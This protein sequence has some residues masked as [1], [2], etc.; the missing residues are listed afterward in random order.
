MAFRKSAEAR[1]QI[2]QVTPQAAIPGGEFQIRGKGLLNGERP[3]VNLG[4]IPAHVVIGSESFG[5]VRGPDG[6]SG[7]GELIGVEPGPAPWTCQIRGQVA[8][9]AQPLANPVA[10]QRR[11]L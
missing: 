5:I 9:N 6:A 7:E 8:A 4:G 2:L 3:K 10:G 11:K 1:T